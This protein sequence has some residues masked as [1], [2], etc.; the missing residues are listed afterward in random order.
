MVFNRVKL[1]GQACLAAIQ[2]LTRFPVPVNVPFEKPVLTRSI[3]YFPFAGLLIGFCLSAAAWAFGLILPPW[4]AAVLLLA[5]WVA[6]SGG[7]HLDGWMDTA[8][9]V[10]SHRDRD[11]MLD[12][13][14]DSRVGAMGVLAAVLLLL[15]KASLLAE[16]LK[17]SGRNDIPLGALLIG[18]ACLGRA[19]MAAAI[20]GWKPARPNE[21]IG[22]LFNGVNKMSVIH[23]LFVAAVF[24]F[25]SLM[26]SGIN[27]KISILLLFSA[28]AITFLCGWAMASWLNKKLG[29]LTGDTYGAMN[30]AVETALLLAIV[31]WQQTTG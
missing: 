10:L 29:G 1:H 21:G 20:G 8:D 30:E 6:L 3:I 25:T 24:S 5:L 2:F 27:Y 15:L 13:M 16:L 19:W 31:I 7:L 4:P 9:G 22:R 18:C 17:N 11:K 12:I 28:L 26:I 14:K 23:S